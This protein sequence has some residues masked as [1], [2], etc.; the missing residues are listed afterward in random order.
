MNGLA[1]Q[2]REAL[3]LAMAQQLQR[4]HDAAVAAGNCAAAVTASRALVDLLSL[5]LVA[6]EGE[7]AQGT[8]TRNDDL[9]DMAR[10]KAIALILHRAEHEQ[11][12][13]L[14]D[15]DRQIAANDERPSSL[16]DGQA[17]PADGGLAQRLLSVLAR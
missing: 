1:A 6:V 2:T 11:D 7:T 3:L 17:L 5:R 15:G 4:D 9:T 14:S 10:A 13:K 8:A 12:L 16:L